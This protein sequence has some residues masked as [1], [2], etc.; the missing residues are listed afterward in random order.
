M[1]QHSVPR[2]YLKPWT[3]NGELYYLN[4]TT[5]RI[6][7]CGVRGV[8]NERLFY[9]LEKLTP[10]EVDLIK[11]GLIEPCREPLRSIQLNFLRLY[12][13]APTLKASV[14]VNCID[15]KLRS[16]LED[17][18]ANAAE[19]Y[20]K[21]IEDC[22]KP[23]IAS[24]LKGDTNFYSDAKK[25]A[26]FLYAISVQFTRTNRA[27][28]AF[29]FKM[30]GKYGGCNP[31]RIWN[32]ASHILATSV[33]H[34][35]YIDRQQFKLLLLDN[36][37]DTPFITGDQPIINLDADLSSKP[38]NKLEY[39]YPL[40]PKKAMLLVE[41]SNPICAGS[42]SQIAVNHYNVLIA[43]NSYE[44]VYSNRSDYLETIRKS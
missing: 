36:D 10:E 25:V 9:R 23:F 13:F 8:A 11:R 34:S 32:V 2:F 27:K 15:P 1:G 33:G 4:R 39:F 37:T 31:Q 17:Q 12:M 14:D 35:L 28:Q 41:N 6:R 44:Q 38:P 29:D 3:Q 19:H 40:S 43:K 5:G 20:H 30:S 24:M 16:L 42:V 18:I 22:L 26:N 21:R 7:H